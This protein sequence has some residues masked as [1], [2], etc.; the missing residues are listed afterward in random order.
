VLITAILVAELVAM[1]VVVP[2]VAAR[3]FPGLE[4][5]KGGTVAGSV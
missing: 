1:P 2:W 5:R 3:R 4:E